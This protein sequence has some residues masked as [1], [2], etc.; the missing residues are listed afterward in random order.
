MKALLEITASTPLAKEMM[1]LTALVRLGELLLVGGH[2]NVRCQ[3]RTL[4][5]FFTGLHDI[6]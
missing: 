2:D 1:V 5:Y 4:L 3:C 6:I